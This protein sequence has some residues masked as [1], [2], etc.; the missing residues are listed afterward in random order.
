[1]KNIF[2]IFRSDIRMIYRNI[3][4]FVVIIGITILPA[5]YSWFNI[6]SNWD[7]YSATSGI[8]FA[9]CNKDVGYSYKSIEVNAGQQITDSLKANDKMGWEFVDEKEAIDGVD[10]GKYYAAVIIPEKFSENLC[11]ITTGEFE[12]STLD[13]YVNEKKNAIAPKITNSGMSTIENEVKS[14]YVNTVTNVLATMLNITADEYNNDKDGA[15]KSIKESLQNIIDEV[16][17]F[18]TT[19]DVFISTLDMLDQLIKTNKELLPEISETLS[20]SG[21]ITSDVKASIESTRNASAQISNA[22]GNILA[23]ADQ[24]QV[25]INTRLTEAFEMLEGDASGAAGELINITELNNKIITINSY[26]ISILESIRDSFGIDV[27]SVL[28]KLYNAN[29]HQQQLI[30]KLYSAAMTLNNTG[31]LPSDIRTE[32][33]NLVE[34]CKVDLSGTES[35]FA[36]IKDTLSKTVDDVY[37]VLESASGLLQIVNG[38]IPAIDAT[39]DSA[40]S[41]ITEMKKTFE[42]VKTLMNNSKKK[43]ENLIKVVDEVADGGEISDVVF[44]IIEDPAALST[45][46]SDPVTTE[47][48]AL[49]GVENYGSAMSP[50]YTSLGIWV[51]G[52]V[53]AAVIRAELTN[54]QISKLKRPRNYQMYFGRYILFFIIA[55]MQALIISLGD[56]YF[57]GIQCNNKF[58]FVFGSMISA[59]VYSLIIYSLTICFNVIG[60]ALAVIILVLQVAGSGGTFPVEVLPAPFQSLVP[61]LPF[62]YGNDILREAIAGP[63]MSSYWHNVLMLLAFVPF[64]LVVGILLRRPCIKLMHFF[65]K[66][67]H[68]SD[69][70]I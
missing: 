43:V 37:D 36:V 27:S 41:A 23:S 16:D 20:K 33:V 39:L 24:M 14:A 19:C 47:T 3:I 34:S 57:L 48:H 9:V 46:F 42:E 40:G 32:I 2:L 67:I 22:V 59:L 65:D 69:L 29:D 8:S 11:S 15:V 35:S 38:D 56:I 52:I 70:I 18:N 60:K 44:K 62:R 58:L 5:L 26:V 6:A 1:M 10:S 28:D 4:A 7:P 21:V 64:A 51:G 61:Y 17:A 63:D 54:S 55:E 50:F 68:Q 53:L 31:E 49:H 25:N 45:F 13:Y 12:Q 30:D 66:R